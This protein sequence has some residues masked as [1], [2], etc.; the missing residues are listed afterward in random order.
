MVRKE[1]SSCFRTFPLVCD[2]VGWW[3]CCLISDLPFLF[4]LLA[5]KGFLNGLKYVSIILSSVTCCISHSWTQS[6]NKISVFVPECTERPLLLIEHIILGTAAIK[7]MGSTQ[8]HTC[9]VFKSLLCL[10][11]WDQL[12]ALLICL[13]SH[14]GLEYPSAV[15]C[16]G[17]GRAQWSQQC[18]AVLFG[19][20]A[21]WPAVLH[22]WLEPGGSVYLYCFEILKSVCSGHVELKHNGRGRSVEERE[23]RQGSSSF[24]PWKEE[25]LTEVK[26]SLYLHFF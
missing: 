11:H 25:A 6:N 16:P 17:C 12:L 2:C 19:N 22:V 3:F 26:Q 13:C 4:R 1:P 21:L 23:W 14:A 7:Y 5:I 20:S 24:Q 8:L 18:S 9:F 15:R 10:L